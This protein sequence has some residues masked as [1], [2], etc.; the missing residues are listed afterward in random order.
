[1]TESAKGSIYQSIIAM[2]FRARQINDQIKL[3][4]TDRMSSIVISQDETEGSNFDQLSISREFDRLPKPTFMAMKEISDDKITFEIPA[5]EEA[6][7]KE[8]AE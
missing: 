8:S 2:G 5:E 3:E 7:D 6:T 1:M 4:L